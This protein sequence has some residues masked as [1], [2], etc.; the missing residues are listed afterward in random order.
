MAAGLINILM[1]IN[2]EIVNTLES[3]NFVT[4]FSFQLFKDYFETKPKFVFLLCFFSPR[5]HQMN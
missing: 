3:F 1:K 5:Q 2:E 4:I